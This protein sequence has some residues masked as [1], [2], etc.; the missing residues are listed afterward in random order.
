MRHLAASLVVGGRQS[1][2]AGEDL[3]AAGTR[4]ALIDVEVPHRS[5][6]M[7]FLLNVPRSAS[8]RR[9]RGQNRSSVDALTV[10]Q[11]SLQSMVRMPRRKSPFAWASYQ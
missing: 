11:P 7:Q 1:R 9:G 2:H 6:L 5:V 4:R 3:L 8:I 10:G